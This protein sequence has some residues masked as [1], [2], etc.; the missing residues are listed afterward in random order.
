[1][2][3]LLLILVLFSDPSG[4]AAA[5]SVAAELSR[6]G[7]ASVQVQVGAEALKTLEQRGVRDG[8]LV[9]TPAIPRQLTA[10]EPNLVVIR[11]E[12]RS[13][14]GD[15]VVESRIWSGGVVESHVAIAGQGGDPTASAIN[16]IIQVV[17]PRLPSQPGVAPTAEEGRLAQLA[18]QQGWRDLLAILGPVAQKS[19]RQFYYLVLALVSLGEREQA[20]QNLEAMRKAHPDHFLIKA[21]AALM[22]VIV[23]PPVEPAPAPTPAPAANDADG[24]TLRDGPAPKDER[25]NTLR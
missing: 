4:E 7:G 1:M 15:E 22:P 6:L 10:S 21:A 3:N 11:I 23:A 8:D 20:E 18:A 25:G 16:G 12:C 19:P 17:G 2:S 14:G 9:L 24:N 13:T 5:K